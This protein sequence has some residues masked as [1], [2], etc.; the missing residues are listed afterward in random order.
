MRAIIVIGVAGVDVSGA[1]ACHGT[2]D[3]GAQADL[4]APSAAVCGVW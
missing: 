4:L 3:M 1:G 2:R